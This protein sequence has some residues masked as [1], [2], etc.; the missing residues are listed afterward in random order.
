MVV[1]DLHGDWDAYRR[2]RDRFVA[3]QAAGKADY[4]IFTGDLIHRESLKEPDKSLEIVLDV[5]ALQGSY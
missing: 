2:Y 1:T 5:I 4:F 3:L